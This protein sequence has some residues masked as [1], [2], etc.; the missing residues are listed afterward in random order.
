MGVSPYDKFT[1]CET[2]GQEG[3]NCTGHLAHVELLLPVYNPFLMDRLIKLLK[4]YYFFILRYKCFSCHKLR[5][6]QKKI[7]DFCNMLILL[8]LGYITEC[9]EFEK[10]I[11]N[12]YLKEHQKS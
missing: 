1:K 8:K 6:P 5:I 2:C 10:T 7:D 3:I 11:E 9:H 12:K 4:F